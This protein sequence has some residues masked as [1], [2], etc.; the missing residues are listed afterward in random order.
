MRIRPEKLGIQLEKARGTPRR[1]AG[2]CG[3]PDLLGAQGEIE[4]GQ[5]LLGAYYFALI[6]LLVTVAPKSAVLVPGGIVPTSVRLTPL[7]P[8]G[9]LIPLFSRVSTPLRAVNPLTT[10]LGPPLAASLHIGAGVTL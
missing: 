2:S 3:L 8:S 7:F 10:D 5:R 1:A 6:M 9:A 4:K